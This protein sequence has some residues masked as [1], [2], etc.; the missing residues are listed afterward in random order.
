VRTV[1]LGPSGLDVSPISLGTSVFGSQ[2][3]QAESFAILDAAVE[4]G[5]NFIDTADVYPAG[6]GLS[7]VTEAVIGK[8][9]G[10]HRDE[11]AIATKCG[12]RLSD[13]PNDGGLSR[14]HVIEACHGSLRR[15][16]VETIDVF[17]LH[18]MDPSVSLEETFDA[19]DSLVR[20]G[21]VHYL[22]LS[23]F[24]ARTTWRAQQVTARAGLSPITT[25]LTKYNMLDRQAAD[26]ILPAAAAASTGVFVWNA[27][28]GGMLTGKY[29]RGDPPPAGSRYS[30]TGELGDVY[31]KRY[32][33]GGTFDLV[34]LLLAVA[35]SEGVSPG[36]AALA[37]TLSQRGVTGALVGASKPDHVRMAARAA[38]VKLSPQ[39]LEALDGWRPPPDR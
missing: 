36:E 29:R 7:G 11:V 10:R 18:V 22:G 28:A 31:R 38:D 34:D 24:D 27:L 13:R 37:W 16:N 19:L 1:K 9:L 32:W 5:I 26:E 8:W 30:D 6:S 2:C 20:G 39:A 21:K 3:T 4:A 17:Y 25:L 33:S 35:R 14:K 23:N 12:H 15:L